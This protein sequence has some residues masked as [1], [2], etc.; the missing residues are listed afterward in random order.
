MCNKVIQFFL[1][2]SIIVYYE[3]LNIVPY[4]IQ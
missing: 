2:F 4:N 1:F 3:V